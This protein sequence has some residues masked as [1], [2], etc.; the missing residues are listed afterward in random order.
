MNAEEAIKMTVYADFEE[1]YD[2]GLESG[3][4]GYFV[5]VHFIGFGFNKRQLAEKMDWLEKVKIEHE[6]TA[7]HGLN[8]L[9][10]L[11]YEYVDG[12]LGEPIWDWVPSRRHMV[13]CFRELESEII[14]E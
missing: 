7:L 5:D 3:Y 12:V 10:S 4:V 1:Q 6:R 9:I 8:D 2:E 11:G 14:I 13:K